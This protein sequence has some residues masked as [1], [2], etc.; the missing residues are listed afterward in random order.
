[1]NQENTYEVVRNEIAEICRIPSEEVDGNSN[2]FKLGFDSLSLIQLI[3]IIEV[4]FNIKLSLKD[5]FIYP[6]VNEI[7]ASIE[8]KRASI[9]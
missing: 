4:T 5:V 2:L 6:S 7:V 8:T 3:H 9:K 1:M